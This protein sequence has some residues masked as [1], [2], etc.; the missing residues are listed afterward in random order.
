MGKPEFDFQDSTT[1]LCGSDKS[2]KLCEP[3]FSHL[4]NEDNPSI[5]DSKSYPEVQ[6]RSEKIFYS[7]LYNAIGIAIFIISSII[8]IP[9]PG[10][11]WQYS[12]LSFSA[13]LEDFWNN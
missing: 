3:K 10:G 2:L 1:W 9:F 12:V 11:R 6:M 8:L 7:V 13:L 4:S 5:P